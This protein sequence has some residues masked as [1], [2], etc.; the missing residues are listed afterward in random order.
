VSGILDM[1]NSFLG[2]ERRVEKLEN[3]LKRLYAKAHAVS[4]AVEGAIVMD[5]IHGHDYDG[6][7]FLENFKEIEELLGIKPERAPG[8][9]T[10]GEC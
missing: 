2:D 7:T 4:K 6:P 9:P 8:V 10:G 5:S 1:H 3:A